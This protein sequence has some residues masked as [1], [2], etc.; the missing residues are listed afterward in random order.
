MKASSCLLRNVAMFHL[1]LSWSLSLSPVRGWR[2]LGGPGEW[3]ELVA[4]EPVLVWQRS[5]D[6]VHPAAAQQP[7]LLLT[8]PSHTEQPAPA[9]SH[10]AG[11]PRVAFHLANRWATPHRP[12]TLTAH[13]HPRRQVS[14]WRKLKF[15]LCIFFSDNHLQLSY[16]MF[17]FKMNFDQLV[18]CL[19]YF[20]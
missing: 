20:R 18:Q 19:Y 8:R 6:R 11:L 17:I 9:A 3:Y 2:G 13:A 10:C 4:G 15:S 5:A 14:V 7:E 16:W 12:P 1:H